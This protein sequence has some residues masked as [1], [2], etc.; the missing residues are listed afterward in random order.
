MGKALCMTDGDSIS[1]KKERKKEVVGG[2]EGT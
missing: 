1:I 2:W